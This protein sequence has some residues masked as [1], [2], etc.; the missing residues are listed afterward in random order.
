MSDYL[1]NKKHKYK[2][3]QFIEGYVP[4]DDLPRP[5]QE[6]SGDIIISNP[7]VVQK[8]VKQSGT[9]YIQELVPIQTV[10]DGDLATLSTVSKS[11]VPHTNV[12]VALNGRVVVPADGPGD[13]FN[14]ACYFESLDNVIRGVGEVRIGDFLK[15][16]GSVAGIE[17]E[18][19]D[20]LVI[21]YEVEEL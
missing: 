13:V 1:K 17:V 16:N 11:P 14:S 19:T 21:I 12:I 9:N 4:G 2:S 3:N 10:N 15:W 5:V 7:I 8:N 20:E 18:P 6:I